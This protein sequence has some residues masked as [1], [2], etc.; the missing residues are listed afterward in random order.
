MNPV[1]FLLVDDLEENLLSLEALLR[2]PDLVL[3]KA[4][5]GDEA[6]ELLLSHDVALALV[7]VQMPGL[8][9]F[10]LAELM[11]GNE[12]T[13]RIP[14]IFVTAGSADAQRKFRG[15]ETG[16][17]DFIQ[18]PIES[19][20]LRSKA[21]VFFELYRQRQQLAVQRDELEAQ[22]EALKETGRRKD[23]FLLTL[24][25]DLTLHRD[26]RAQ[27]DVLLREINHRIKN[28]FT[29]TSGL[30]SLSAKYATTVAEL[31]AD[32]KSRLRALSDAH[33][34]TLPDLTTSHSLEKSTTSVI[35]LLEKILAPHERAH[36]SR[37]RL[38][39]DDVPLRGSA[40]TSLALLLHELATNAAKYG[41]L[42]T[43]DGR[44]TIELVATDDQLRTL[45]KEEG[46]PGPKETPTREGFGTKLEKAL[47]TA[48]G[49]SVSRSWTDDGLILELR[50]PLTS[51]VQSPN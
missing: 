22:A 14:I 33:D 32:L 27:Q 39:G 2:R 6:L 15:Y 11:R 34:L 10:E 21:E 24:T 18:K 31:S 7:D 4:R 44:L 43:P 46:V 40:L 41:A 20:I 8:N 16:A 28:L 5:S 37:I 25:Q 29:L 47:L 3:L 45:W 19:D 12:R 1:H 13:R 50:M 49:G 51:L 36:E 23:E 9:G 42:A 35:A 38:I 17:V 48:L 26:A 30:I